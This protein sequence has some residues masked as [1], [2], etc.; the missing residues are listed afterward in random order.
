MTILLH[1]YDAGS[2]S[3]LGKNEPFKVHSM[4]RKKMSL[5]PT[6][7]TWGSPTLLFA[8]QISDFCRFVQTY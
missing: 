4:Q 8:R 3:R 1:C 7:C 5:R 2:F 6:Q